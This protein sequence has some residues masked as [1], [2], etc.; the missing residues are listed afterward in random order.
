[1][2]PLNIKIKDKRFFSLVFF[3]LVVSC[4]CFMTLCDKIYHKIL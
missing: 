1:M 4:R 3:L 2:R